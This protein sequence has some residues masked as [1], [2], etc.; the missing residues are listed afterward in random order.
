MISQERLRKYARLAVRM[1]VGVQKGQLLVLNASVDCAYFARLCAEEAYT[2]GAGEVRL[3]WTDELMEK[4]RYEHEGEETLAVVPGWKVEQKRSDIDRKACF[5]YISSDTPGLLGHIP[6]ALLQKVM[7]AREEAF[8]PFQYYTMANH[9]QWCIVAIPTAAWAS[10]VFP[11]ESEEKALEKLWDAVLMSVRVGEE[12]DPV[13]EWQRHNER[14]ARN[15]ARLNELNFTALH[16]VNSLGTDLTVGLIQN[17]VWA[18]GATT[19]KNGAVFNPNMPSEEIFTMPAKFGVHGRVTAT[20][21][22]N[23]QGKTI[24]NFWFRF[25]EGKVVEYGAEKGSDV[26][27]NLVEFDEGSAYLGEVAL[28]PFHSPISE[29]G[30]L[31]LSTLF[32][33]NASCHL[34]LGRAYPENVKG[35]AEMTQEELSALGSNYSM[36]HCDFMF[37]SADL[38]IDGI[39]ASG[40]RV[41]V[42]EN[43]DFIVSAGF[44][45]S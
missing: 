16:F 42:F 35:G 24:E 1:G 3:N 26:L 29:S 43:G 31:F 17:H 36:E 13:A 7:L 8:E 32:D 2:A 5:L 45:R 18:G 44:E 27:K 12:N 28:I 23:Y 39:T 11:G 33:E 9:G 25:E 14:L 10:K 40:E 6:G 4:L 41:A 20:K 37:G 22:L 15:S 21:P 30:V 38:R 19:A 34:A